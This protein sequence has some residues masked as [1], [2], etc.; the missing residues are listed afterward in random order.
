VKK[1]LLLSI[2]LFIAVFSLNAQT[3]K[4]QVSDSIIAKPEYLWLK[5]Y[6]NGIFTLKD[7]VLVSNQNKNNIS[8]NIGNYIGYTELFYKNKNANG[9]GFIY[10][11]KE[12][13]FLI[14]FTIAEF[15]KGELTFLNSIENLKN[16]Q[17]QEANK[18]ADAALIE[19]KAKY[20]KQNRFDSFSINKLLIYERNF[21]LL[22]DIKNQ[23]CDSIIKKDTF[24]FSKTIAD[25]IKTPTANSN[26]QLKKYFDN[27]DAMLH[28]HYFDAID[29]SN[30]LTL[31]HP[32]YNSK[33]EEYFT[34]YCDKNSFAQG[35]DVLMK[36]ATAND[37]VKNYTFN[38]LID[39]FLN[40]K[41][42]ALITYLNEKY[43]D[44]CGLKLEAEKLKEFSSIV[45]T[46]I[47]AKIPDVI[48][49]D[50]K[51]EIHSL[52]NEAEKNKY[53]LV[54]IWT[55]WCHAC[56]KHTP[57]I[58]EI[59][60]AYKKKGLGVFA[61]SLDEK[62]EDWLLAIQKYKINNW[63]NVAELTSLQNSTILPKLNIR[64]TPKIFIIDKNGIIVAKDVTAD[65]LKLKFTQLLK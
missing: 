51:N 55:S 23:L 3:L 61:I 24:L 5:V 54:Y 41:Q 42:D 57:I 64:T 12:R 19:L 52:Y 28:W 38:Y 58:L 6:S 65:E 30:P 10:N 31:N 27:Y 62:K 34:K 37:V 7:S 14:K 18:Q 25:F 48:S 35:V 40:R 56:Q 60:D 9:L 2:L 44:G 33:I 20:L 4:I 1:Y 46:Q 13:D 63:V 53:T 43:A 17:L 16:M 32:A 39:Y 15:D 50:N 21:E 36:K 22:A 59:S 11:F 29:F 26:K 8:F 47:G 45:Q 49:Y